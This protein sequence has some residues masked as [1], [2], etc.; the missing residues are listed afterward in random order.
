MLVE[1]PKGCIVGLQQ[2]QLLRLDVEVHGT[3]RGSEN[4]QETI[5]QY[6]LDLG[7]VHTRADACAF[8]L[9]PETCVKPKQRQNPFYDWEW[10]TSTDADGERRELV[11]TDGRVILVTDD[12]MD[13]G[14]EHC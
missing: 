5:R 2:G 12:V 10:R 7:Y 14:N 1:Q 11:A 4:W 8:I 6:I 13:S 3:I 9:K